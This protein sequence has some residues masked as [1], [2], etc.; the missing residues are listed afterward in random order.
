MSDRFGCV[1]VILK[2]GGQVDTVE[3]ADTVC[4]SFETPIT[5]TISY[6]ASNWVIIAELQLYV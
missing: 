6:T 5:A 4:I 1:V 2:Q 3:T